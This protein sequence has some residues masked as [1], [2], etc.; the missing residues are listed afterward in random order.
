LKTLLLSLAVSDFGVGLLCQPFTVA[1]CAKWLQQNNPDVNC[2]AYTVFAI[3]VT[4][5]SFA[6]FFGVMLMSV[7][8]FMAIYLHPRYQEL[9]TYNRVAAVVISVFCRHWNFMY[10]TNSSCELQDICGCSTLQKSNSNQIQALQV[11]PAGRNSVF[12]ESICGQYL[13]CGG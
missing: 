4:L 12:K 11:Q 1:L 9:V 13:W 3:I 5:F 10:D 2:I 7:D 8:R 6:S